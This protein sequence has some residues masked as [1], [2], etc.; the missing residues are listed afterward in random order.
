VEEGRSIGIQENT[1]L[2]GSIAGSM[3]P[4]TG[5]LAV[6]TGGTG[7]LGYEIA[8]S[9]ARGGA[10]VVIAG[11][12]DAKGRAAAARIRTLAPKALVRFEKLDL[13]ELASVAAFAGRLAATSQSVDLLINNAGVMALPERRVTADGFEMQL[14]INYLGHFALTGHLFP[15]LRRSR[16]ARVVQ[17][18]SLAHRLGKIYFDDLQ[19]EHGYGPWKAYCQSK[20]ATLL[21]ARELQWQ[22]AARGWGLLSVAAHPGYAQTDLFV[23]GRGAKSALAR[24]SGSLGKVVSQSAADG[25]MPALFAA[26]SANVEPGGFYGPGGFFELAGPPRPAHASKRALDPAVAQKLW[27]VSQQLTG[28]KWS[29]G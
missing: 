7:G 12:D 20:L 5:R 1:L 15:L 29:V 16:F 17:M 3:P 10:D 6:V 21:F 14:G 18:S 8:L 19:A 2:E 28:V 11:R 25:A 24:L 26:T 4:Q 27:K 9:L 22:S 13:A 23:N